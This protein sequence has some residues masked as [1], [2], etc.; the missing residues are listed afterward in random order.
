MTSVENQL[1]DVVDDVTVTNNTNDDEKLDHFAIITTKEDLLT[2]TKRSTIPSS[3]TNIMESYFD[4]YGIENNDE[5]ITNIIIV[6]VNTLKKN[7]TT[8]TTTTLW[9]GKKRIPPRKAIQ[10]TKIG[11]VLKAQKDYPLFKGYKLEQVINAVADVVDF[12]SKQQYLKD[13]KDISGKNHIDGF[14]DVTSFSKA[15]PQYYLDLVEEQK[16]LD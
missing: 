5:E 2:N 16:D 10:L 14:Y 12:R 4:K 7:H 3:A 9:L 13:I 11:V 8:T 6:G 1:K 15:I